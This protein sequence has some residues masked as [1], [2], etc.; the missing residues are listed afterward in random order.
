MEE[1]NLEQKA[2]N[3]KLRQKFRL[4]Q[5]EKLKQRFRLAQYEELVRAYRSHYQHNQYME[6]ETEHQTLG[7]DP[8]GFL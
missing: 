4:L 8:S 6:E 3:E 5:Y 1:E 7:H 2:E